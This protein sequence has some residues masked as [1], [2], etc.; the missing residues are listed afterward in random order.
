[1]KSYAPRASYIDVWQCLQCTEGYAID[2]IAQE[3]HVALA[4]GIHAGVNITIQQARSGEG[5]T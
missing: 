3:K 4:D 1:M 5:V 2:V